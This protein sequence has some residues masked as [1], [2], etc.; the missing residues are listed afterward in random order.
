MSE[1]GVSGKRSIAWS[2]R[3]ALRRLVKK[4]SAPGAKPDALYTWVRRKLSRWMNRELRK[5]GVGWSE[6][7]DARQEVLLRLIKKMNKH[8]LRVPDAFMVFLLRI[9]QSVA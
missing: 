2:A 9:V 5:R 4:A 6:I 3:A 7:E 1:K 8:Q